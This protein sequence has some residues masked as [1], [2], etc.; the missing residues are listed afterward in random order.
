MEL[1]LVKASVKTSF[2]IL[3]TLCY[4]YLFIAV[5][6]NTSFLRRRDSIKRHLQEKV[7]SYSKEQIIKFLRK[8]A[9]QRQEYLNG[10][11]NLY[12]QDSLQT[13]KINAGL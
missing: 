11:A 8:K 13:D 12:H 3:L 4:L 6:E 2:I 5:R 1:C 7:Q 9:E 10:M